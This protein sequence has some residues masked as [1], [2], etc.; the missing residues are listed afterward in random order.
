MIENIGIKRKWLIKLYRQRDNP[1]CRDWP[2]TTGKEKALSGNPE[3]QKLNF[4]HLF[5][6][7]DTLTF[8]H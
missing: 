5:Y 4:N 1:P 6:P 2:R 8:Q 7:V 3:R